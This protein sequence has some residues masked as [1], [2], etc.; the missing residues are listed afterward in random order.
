MTW[1]MELL[2][3]AAWIGFVLCLRLWVISLSLV[4]GQSMDPT[5]HHREWLL[6]WR[7]PYR[8]RGPR[9]QDVVICHF[10]SRRGGVRR[11]RKLKLLPQD[12]VKRVIGVPGDTL[13]FED[14]KLT[15]NGRELEEPYLDAGLCRWMQ[16]RPPVMLGEDEYFVLGDNRDHSNDSRNVGML[17]RRDIR[18]RVTHVFW[19]PQKARRV[20]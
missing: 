9:R 6:V 14:G 5:L 11:H 10:P 3:Y 2:L 7:L 4:Q 17:R 13:I 20:E 8:F 12:F 19:P 18:G 16:N 15:V 1:W